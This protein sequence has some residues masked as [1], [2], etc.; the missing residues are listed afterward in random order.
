[1]TYRKKETREGIAASSKKIGNEKS[2]NSFANNS[3]KNQV[4]S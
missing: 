4:F 3:G 2:N 1:L